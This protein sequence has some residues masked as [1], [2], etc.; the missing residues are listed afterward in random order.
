MKR[1]LLLVTLTA[2]LLC[3]CSV[4]GIDT[5]ASAE[6]TVSAIGFD[7]TDDGTVATF[8]VI[9][10]NRDDDER[11]PE[12]LLFSAT[13]ETPE[14]AAKKAE[15]L[16]GVGFTKSHTASVIIGNTV[17]GDLFDGITEYC[18]DERDI[19]VAVAVFCAE[20]AK[21]LLTNEPITSIAVGYEIAS[22]LSAY[23]TPLRNRLYESDSRHFE[24]PELFVYGNSFYIGG[25]K[26][27]K[28]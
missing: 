4:G 14:K 13:G 16:S 27:G 9:A 21:D 25:V 18:I 5:G 28:P 26:N 23:K 1:L 3:G 19:S 6:Y 8:E 2:F 17:K 12:R 11:K 20:N 10:V 24:M 7:K 22:V 15:K